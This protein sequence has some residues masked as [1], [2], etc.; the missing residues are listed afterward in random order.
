MQI[1]DTIEI[2]G[3]REAGSYTDGSPASR[4]VQQWVLPKCGTGTIKYRTELKVTARRKGASG[5]V[6]SEQVQY[7]G[8]P[9]YYGAQQGVSY[10]FEKC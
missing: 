6:S 3:P 4:R 5:T 10:D 7:A 8:R 2:A 9:T 1:V